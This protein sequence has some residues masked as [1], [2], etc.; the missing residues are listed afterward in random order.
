[1]KKLLT[2]VSVALAFSTAG[3]VSAF[4]ANVGGEVS[5]PIS[6]F[7]LSFADPAVKVLAQ[8][9]SNSSNSGDEA[10]HSQS[11]WQTLVSEGLITPVGQ[12]SQ[13]NTDDK[14]DGKGNG[15]GNASGI[16]TGNANGPC[17]HGQHVGNKHCVP[18]PSE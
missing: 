12:D 13:A 7:R 9:G 10:S 2:V 1:M 14:S 17:K 18:S 8:S 11:E 15:N 16:F 4:C 3:A 6:L 5:E